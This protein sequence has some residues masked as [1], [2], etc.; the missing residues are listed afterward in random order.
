MKEIS[1]RVASNKTKHLLV[2]TE[3]K[4][5]EKIDAAYFR[6]KNYFEGGSTENYL[7]FQPMSKYFKTFVEGDS[8]Y[9][10]PWEPKGLSNEKISSINTS[11]YSQAPTLVYDNARIKLSFN[12]DFLKQDK[13]T[14]NHEPVVNINTVY[15]LT[16]G[17][18]NSS[19]TLENCLTGTFKLTKKADIDK[20]KYSGHGIGFYSRGSF[21]HPSGGYGK[22]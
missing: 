12:T 22:A 18:N 6:G 11:N 3:L 10:S 14:Y 9:I 20:Y 7:V 5:L 2:E 4:K 17:I 16:R 8:T 19:V 15:G 13:V 1:G 21:T